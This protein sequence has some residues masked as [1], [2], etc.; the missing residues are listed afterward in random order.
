MYRTLFNEELHQIVEQET[1]LLSQSEIQ[2]L[3]DYQGTSGTPF[4]VVLSEK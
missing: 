2:L 4:I 1:H 3:F